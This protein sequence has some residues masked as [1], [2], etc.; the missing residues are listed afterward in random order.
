M[1]LN[2]RS[3]HTYEELVEL[4][5]A[6]DK[7]VCKSDFPDLFATSGFARAWW[8][9]YGEDRNLNIVVVQNDTGTPRLI[10]PFQSSKKTPKNWE[11]IGRP[12][13][14][15]NNFVM[16]AGDQESLS[17]LFDWLKEQNDWQ[18]LILRRVPGQSTLLHFF[19]RPYNE[20]L[21]LREKFQS[22]M[23]LRSWLVYQERRREHPICNGTAFQ[24]MHD[25]L[26]HIHH[27]RK[28]NWLKTLGD[29]EYKVITDP[30]KIIEYLPKFF[31]LHCKEWNKMLSKGSFLRHQIHRDFYNYI[32]QEMACYNALRFDAMTLN[33]SLIAAHIGFQYAGRLY[34]WLACYDS[35]YRKGSP[36]RL[37]L[38]NIIH[39][40]LQ[41]GLE[42]LDMLFGLEEYKSAFKSDIR[43]TG[44]LTIYRSPLIAAKVQK[45]W[46]PKWYIMRDADWG[47]E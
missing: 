8:R 17:C 39:S 37:L 24:E 29:L 40:A 6:W 12:R 23:K 43:E 25:V 20:D 11:M 27:R 1:S 9:A 16:E 36:G 14:D 15:Y 2:C 31:D 34:Y 7:L 18:V 45:R 13:G 26:E 30:E 5:K 32:V 44:A 35:N 4:S 19:E 46:H 28:T 38:G 33:D 21:K 42:E 10:A 3:I 41:L 47:G 22:W